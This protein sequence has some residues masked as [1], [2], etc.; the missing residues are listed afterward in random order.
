MNLRQRALLFLLLISLIGCQTAPT[1]Q[2]RY[3]Q[4]NLTIP[5][6]ERT[7]WFVPTIPPSV[8][9]VS[10][11]PDIQQATPVTPASHHTACAGEGC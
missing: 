9:G 6:A 8:P 7:Y 5:W 1:P 4:R 11:P 2:P 10:A 3:R